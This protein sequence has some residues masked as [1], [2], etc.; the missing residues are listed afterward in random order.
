MPLS[1]TADGRRL[2]C[3]NPDSTIFVWD[4]TGQVRD[5]GD[6]RPARLLDKELKS[7]WT[8][9]E[10]SDAM[11][12]GNAIWKLVA[13]GPTTVSFMK[14]QLRPIVSR[15]SLEV[16]DRLFADLDADNFAVREKA[17]NKLEQLGEECESAVRQA[18]TK[19]LSLEVQSSLQRFLSQLEVA[20]NDPVGE[21]LRGVRAVEVL[22][23]IGTPE[24]RQVLEEM[25]R[26]MTWSLQGTY[27]SRLNEE[28]HAALKRSK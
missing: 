12:A 15:T 3:G 4:V 11:K 1:F 5:G 9:L 24:A 17:Q 25:T 10:S 6:L 27:W 26:G 28:S 13:A 7:L 18:L 8:D 2:A 14:T 23:Q 21:V 19:Q 20:K 22:E 16:M